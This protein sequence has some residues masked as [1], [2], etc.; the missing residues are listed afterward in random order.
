MRFDF[1]YELKRIKEFTARRENR[2]NF[3]ALFII[4]LVIIGILLYKSM[5]IG[6]KY[7]TDKDGK[8]IGISRN[9]DKDFV[10]YPLTVEIEKKGKKIKERL[11]TPPPK[12]ACPC[13]PA[14]GQ[15][16]AA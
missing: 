12:R 16:G 3:L 5:G 4:T 2:M 1:N 10:S 11:C 7:V 14:R 15:V 13:R 8:L 9:S 6:N